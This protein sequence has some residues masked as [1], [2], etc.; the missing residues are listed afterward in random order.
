ML[1][2]IHVRRGQFDEGIALMDR[3]A[4][5]ARGT[6]AGAATWRG[7]IDWRAVKR[8]L[9][10]WPAAAVTTISGSGPAACLAESFAGEEPVMRLDYLFLSEE[11]T[12]S[13]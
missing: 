8:R 3:R 12:C 2:I 9:R 11:T 13:N 1:G 10:H 6:V 5:A 7:P 4:N